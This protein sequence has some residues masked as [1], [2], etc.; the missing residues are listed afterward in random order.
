MDQSCFV[1]KEISND[2]YTN[3][4][5]KCNIY[6]KTCAM[7]LATGGKCK[8]CNSFFTQ[9]KSISIDSIDKEK[10]ENNDSTRK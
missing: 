8:K 10:Q 6:C 4:P 5:C 1:C 3:M 2:L 7:K 9:M